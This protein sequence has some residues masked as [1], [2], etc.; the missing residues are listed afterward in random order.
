MKR[1]SIIIPHYNTP[2]LLKVLLDS[3]P[4]RSEIEVLVIDDNSD[5]DIDEFFKIQE[6]YKKRNIQ[7][8]YNVP[9][10][11][12]AGNARNVGLDHAVGEWVLFA[13]ADDFFVSEFWE[14]VSKYLDSFEDMVYFA[15]TSIV[16]KTKEPS[17]RHPYYEQL[18]ES[19]AKSPSCVNELRI[20]Y[21]FWSPCSKMIRKSII[22]QYKIRF[23]SV[24]YSNDVMF[25]A[26]VGYFCKNIK[27]VH[28]TIYCIT[29]SEKGLTMSKDNYSLRV[30]RKVFCNYYFFIHRKLSKN[31]MSLL[32]YKSS[33]WIHFC[34]EKMKLF[35]YRV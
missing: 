6:I 35:L 21:I 32:G 20:R 7:F 2:E 34:F 10:K 16:L 25:S 17:D 14:I 3:I 31:D 23:D 15:P 26:K 18:V 4:N 22:E 30:R 1:L 12:G 8:F 33:A 9:E 5:Q 24:R 27:A 11:K 19:Y 29:Q 28:K 13:D